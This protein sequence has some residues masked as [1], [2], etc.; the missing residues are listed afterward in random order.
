MS[1]VVTRTRSRTSRSVFRRRRL[2]LLGAGVVVGLVVAAAIVALGPLNDAF[3]E[4]TLPLRHEDIIRQQAH[5]KGLD[6]ALIAAVIY[7]E[8]KFRDRTS[9]AGARGLMQITPE[10]ARFIAHRSGGIRFVQQDLSSPQ[11][12]ISYGSFYLRYLLDRYDGN[13]TLAVAAYNAGLTNVDVWVRRAGGEADFDAARDIP[14][15][16]TRGYVRH[17]L[18]R[19]GQYRDH[20]GHE[21]GY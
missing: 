6:A 14:F 10:T 5:D 2:G 1:P 20:Y 13:R 7:E 11:I 17:V 9:H 15:P 3:K 18:E 19:R 16:E 21:L 4:I 12:N 8:S